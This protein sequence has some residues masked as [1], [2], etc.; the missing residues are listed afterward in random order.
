MC[1]N[2]YSSLP[3]VQWLD[4]HGTGYVGTLRRDRIGFPSDLFVSKHSLDRG[5]WRTW[6]QNNITV[7][8][9]G[10]SVAV[11]LISNVHSPDEKATVQRWVKGSGR[12]EVAAPSCVPT[13]VQYMRGVDRVDQQCASYWPGSKA[14]RWWPSMAWGIINIGV[15]NAYVLHREQCRAAGR[16]PPSNFAF[17]KQ[18]CMEL[19][20]LP[21]RCH[22]E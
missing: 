10:D 4:A 6:Q 9:W 7:T 1:D 19:R 12:T 11:F 13:Y 21:R 8:H 2:H 14:Q 18:L 17:R 20:G 15:H 5:A 3:L 22:E 16:I